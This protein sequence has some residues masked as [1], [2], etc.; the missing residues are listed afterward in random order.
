M[1]SQVSHRRVE[2]DSAGSST[3]EHEDGS[4]SLISVYPSTRPSSVASLTV[5]S[6]P[7]GSTAPTAPSLV[8]VKTVLP[9]A[10]AMS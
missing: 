9:S 7:S 1:W 4:R 5:I 2:P 8:T 10:A 3:A 6:T